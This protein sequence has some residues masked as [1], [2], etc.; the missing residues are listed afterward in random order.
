MQLL[1]AAEGEGVFLKLIGNV[2][3]NEQTG[4]LTTTFKGTPQDPGTPDAPLNEFVLSFSGGPQAALV[5]PPTCGVYTATADFTPWSTPF[6][7]DAL[8]ESNFSITSGPG[9]SGVA[10]CTGPLPF[11]PSLTAG[12]TTDQAAGYTDFSMLLSRGDG[13]QRI[14]KLQFKTPEGLLGKIANVPLCP[15]PQAAAGTCSSA[16]QIGHTVAEVGPGPVPVRDPSRGR[17]AGTDLLDRTV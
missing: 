5:T 15:E 14:E 8:S 6:V 4:Q 1:V 10:N 17:A 11:T 12:S 9:G 16:S 2:H 13:Q 7:E 3:L